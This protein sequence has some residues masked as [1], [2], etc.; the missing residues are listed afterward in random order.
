MFSFLDRVFWGNTVLQYILVLVACIAAWLTIRIARRIVFRRLRTYTGKT[1]GELDDSILEVAEHYIVPFLYI[2]VN[3]IIIR[4]LNLSP[5]LESILK[6]AM[7]IVAAYYIISVINKTMQLVTIGYLKRKNESEQRILQISGLLV[8]VKGLIWF[9]G[10]LFLLDNLGYNITTLLAGL[11]LGGIAIALAAQTVLGDLFGYFV[12]FFDRPFEIGD[13]I[14]V[15]AET[16]TIEHI[17]I[18]TTRIRSVGGEQLI[19]SNSDLTKTVI[20]NFKRLKKRRVVFSVAVSYKIKSDQL[21]QIPQLIK[22]IIEAQPHVS[23][24]RAHLASLGTDNVVF[25]IVY[26]V[27]DS[28]YLVYMDAHQAI[29]YQIFKA[30]EENSITFAQKQ[31]AP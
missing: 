21:L 24:D 11:G 1:E 2:F 7:A 16:G 9:L 14:K 27:D 12:I 13:V 20:H 8:M 5:K 17:G 6:V 29:C 22:S 4:Q 25:E 19:M 23:F 28:D 3:Y 30:F 10:I 31:P 15:G 18:K 26:H